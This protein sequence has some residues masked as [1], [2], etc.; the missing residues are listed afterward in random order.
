M[1]R[2]PEKEERGVKGP[3]DVAP[4]AGEGTGRETGRVPGCSVIPGGFQPD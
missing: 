2:G 4:V 1:G 3:T